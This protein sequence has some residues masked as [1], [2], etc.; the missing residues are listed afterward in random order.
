MKKQ[1]IFPGIIL[2]GFGT[3]FLTQ[4]YDIALFNGFDTWPTLLAIVGIAFLFQGYMAKDYEAIL[5]GVIL[6]GFGLHFHITDRLAIW[7]DS[8]GIFILI[9][10][11]GFLLRAQKLGAGLLQGILF[12]ALAILLLFQEKMAGWLSFL[13]D[14]IGEL[15]KFWPV[16]LIA[17]GLYLLFMKKK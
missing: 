9:I 15:W 10:A 13:E 17:F 11:L 5:P 7:P 12:L 16:L 8:I 6:F 1:R 3:F 4:Q 2:L 14:G